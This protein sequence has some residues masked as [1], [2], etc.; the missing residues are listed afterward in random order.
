MTE[1]NSE[2]IMDERYY[3]QEIFDLVRKTPD[4]KK[5]AKAL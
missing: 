2:E 1:R 3:G 5:L 4:R